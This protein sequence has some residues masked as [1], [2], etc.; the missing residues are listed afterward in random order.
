MT[1]SR[2]RAKAFALF[3]VFVTSGCSMH[4]TY[5][6]TPSSGKFSGDPTL[7]SIAPNTFLFLQPTEEEQK[8]GAKPFSFTTHSE[9]DPNL[10]SRPGR[11]KFRKPGVTIVPE[12]MI[13]TGASV[14]HW[15][16][17][18]SGL[19]AWYHPGAGLIHDWLFEAHHRYEHA[20]AGVHGALKNQDTVKAAHFARRANL[21]KDIGGFDMD[22]SA[23]IYAEA[24]KVLMERNHELL[25]FVDPRKASANRQLTLFSDEVSRGTRRPFILWAYHWAVSSDGGFGI[26]KRVFNPKEHTTDHE[27]FVA[28]QTMVKKNPRTFGQFVSPETAERIDRIVAEENRRIAEQSVNE[29][30]YRNFKIA[31]KAAPKVIEKKK[32]ELVKVAETRAKLAE[33]PATSEGQAKMVELD[34]AVKKL[35]AEIETQNNILKVDQ[36]I[37][38]ALE[39]ALK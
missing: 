34:T 22:D 9:N 32:V 24:I 12:S 5:K 16:W 7:I 11:G 3:V 21:Y 29:E 4:S 18:I 35:N 8:R 13:T 31:K 23:D 10:A 36:Q 28:I 38:S 26:P 39:K 6:K 2:L 15:L 20:M 37:Q 1:C 33:K 17:S 14:P 19:G 27:A 25:R 30:E